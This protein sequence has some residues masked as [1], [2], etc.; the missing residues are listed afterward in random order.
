MECKLYRL[1]RKQMQSYI[2]PWNYFSSIVLFF[3]WS[4]ML[5]VHILTSF[6]KWT[7]TKSNVDFEGVIFAGEKKKSSSGTKQYPSLWVKLIAFSALSR[8]WSLTWRPLCTGNKGFPWSPHRKWHG[9]RQSCLGAS[10]P[11]QGTPSSLVSVSFLS[12]I[13]LL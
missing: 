9:A 1:S 12:K 6:L 10:Y 8:V 3:L 13:K 4:P 2:Q 5:P 11:N 7:K